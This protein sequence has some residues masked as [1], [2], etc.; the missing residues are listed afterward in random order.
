M[1]PQEP[2]KP[3]ELLR[4]VMNGPASPDNRVMQCL[5]AIRGALEQYDCD[6]QVHIAFV[7]GAAM[8]NI[9]VVPNSR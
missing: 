4:S 5:E 2:A 8:P 9:I 7:N 1:A 3:G 6:L